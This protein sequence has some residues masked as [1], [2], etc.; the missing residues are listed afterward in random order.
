MNDKTLTGKTRMKDTPGRMKE[1][2]LLNDGTKFLSSNYVY[3]DSLQEL[4]PERYIAIKSSLNKYKGEI[5]D[6][7]K[8]SSKV[9]KMAEAELNKEI[10]LLNEKFGASFNAEKFLNGKNIQ[11]FKELYAGLNKAINFAMGYD[12]V[13][14]RNVT[15]IKTSKKRKSLFEEDKILEGGKKSIITYYPTYLEQQFQEDLDKIREKLI[16]IVRKNP[17]DVDTMK[18]EMT[19]SLQ[20][21][22]QETCKKAAIRMFS[23]E[24]KL[25]LEAELLKSGALS[26][27]EVL[28][29]RRAYEEL[30]MALEGTQFTN[31]AWSG[32]GAY[33][34]EEIFKLY[35]IQDVIDSL[36]KE[37]LSTRN[38]KEVISKKRG[39][40][41]VKFDLGKEGSAFKQAISV[42]IDSRGGNMLEL[43]ENLTTN[44]A[45][46][47][48]KIFGG[49]YHSGGTGQ[50]KADNIITVGID[51]ST[52]ANRLET[53]YK[54]NKEE[55]EEDDEKSKS[56][57][58]KN[59]RAIDDLHKNLKGINN[60]FIIYSSAKNYTYKDGFGGFS[61]GSGQSIENFVAMF[62]NV[63]RTVRKNFRSVAG[64]ILQLIPDAIG[65]KILDKGE[66]EDLIAQNI[67][68]LLFDDFEKIGYENAKATNALHLMDLNGVFVPLSFILFLLAKAI[69][70]SRDAPHKIAKVSISVPSELMF[71]KVS[72]DRDWTDVYQR[73]LYGDS[74]KAK[75]INQNYGNTSHGLVNI[76]WREQRKQAQ[77]QA[78]ISA[79]FL[80]DFQ[81]IITEFYQ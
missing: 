57:R 21:D 8:D 7:I 81:K 24:R 22:F 74:N 12:E 5:S 3:Y 25:E 60:G 28:E 56:N 34:L 43:V 70:E 44:I 46:S 23:N 62:Q 26:E 15:L 6:A 31:G 29:Q 41:K 68:Y 32:Q 54:N 37:I 67:A 1:Y 76:A 51:I 20:K 77:Q 4:Y 40:S 39:R 61:A 50:M 65:E 72:S 36:T 58:E 17:E 27:Q 48:K 59:I 2:M 55:K 47:N 38:V 80:S 45:F 75:E 11:D 30:K 78:K 53:F 73:V 64:L 33:F 66:I 19:N 18:K 13:Y 79:H 42:A 14:E 16:I 49:S 71:K 52:I 9:Y 69:D 63:H 10:R 35:H